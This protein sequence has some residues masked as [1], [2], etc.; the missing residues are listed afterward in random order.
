ML[1]SLWNSIFFYCNIWHNYKNIY[2]YR[3][4]F[5]LSLK[6]M[7]SIDHFS[8]EL[9]LKTA[10]SSTDGNDT[11]SALYK[12][13]KSKTSPQHTI[14]QTHELYKKLGYK[15][16]AI[17]E[18]MYGMWAIGKIV[19]F[20]NNSSWLYPGDRYPVN[21]QWP[22]GTFEQSIINVW[23]DEV[24]RYK[25]NPQ[26][27]LDNNSSSVVLKLVNIDNAEEVIKKQKEISEKGLFQLIDSI[28]QYKS[29]TDTKEDY[30][31]KYALA[32]IEQK[33]CSETNLL[34]RAAEYINSKDFQ[35]I[36]NK[37]VENLLLDTFA[38]TLL[39]H[40]KKG[41]LKALSMYKQSNR[42]VTKKVDSY[43]LQEVKSMSNEELYEYI[44]HR[45]WTEIENV[46][47][48]KLEKKL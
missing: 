8:W 40:I 33:W 11:A 41:D 23:V 4:Y 9:L 46:L 42:R 19:W 16:W 36:H 30:I 13:L 6:N 29:D 15:E 37:D 24:L 1:F 10:T 26:G 7:N 44:N 39:F 5:I 27:L 12:E 20:R 17:V 14:A 45:K 38:K 22:G 34:Q 47:L 31:Y 35:N 21:V 25:A 43:I 3:V 32:R 28:N 48:E 18:M 2:N